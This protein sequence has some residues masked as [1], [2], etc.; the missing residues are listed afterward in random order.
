MPEGREFRATAIA[1]LSLR[2]SLL[3]NFVSKFDTL[4]YNFYIKFECNNNRAMKK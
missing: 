4:E 3:N 1:A 2:V